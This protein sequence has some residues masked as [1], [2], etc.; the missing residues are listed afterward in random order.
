MALNLSEKTG[1]N[2]N[3]LLRIST[4]RAVDDAQRKVVKSTPCIRAKNSAHDALD[5]L[6]KAARKAPALN[7]IEPVR[8]AEEQ[9]SYEARKENA[10]KIKAARKWLRKQWPAVFNASSPPLAIGVGDTLIEEAVRA[11]IERRIINRTMSKHVRTP[12]YLWRC[13]QNGAL[14]HDLNGKPVEPVSDQHREDAK[15]KLIAI[16]KGRAK[17][18]RALEALK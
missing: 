2:G 18:K 17:A 11:G 10:A 6:R 12:K 1:P 13:A 9:A 16:A 15:T 5:I 8:S 3:R 7:V 14:R 4:P